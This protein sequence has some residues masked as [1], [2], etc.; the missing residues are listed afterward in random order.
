MSRNWRGAPD[1]FSPKRYEYLSKL[2]LSA[3]QYEIQRCAWLAQA[4][5]SQWDERPAVHEAAFDF[6][7][8]QLPQRPQFDSAQGLHRRH[9]IFCAPHMYEPARE[10][11]HI[12]SQ[13][14]HLRRP[15]PVA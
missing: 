13:R 15:E 8:L 10:V 3:W 2:N 14:A 6:F 4:E 9:S 1:W 5:P 12:P 11:D 7:A